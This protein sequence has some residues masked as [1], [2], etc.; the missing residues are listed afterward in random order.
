MKLEKEYGLEG[1]PR[2]VQE[3]KEEVPSFTNMAWAGNTWG[4]YAS[5]ICHRHSKRHTCIQT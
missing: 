4:R 5:Q 2:R 3:L 1:S